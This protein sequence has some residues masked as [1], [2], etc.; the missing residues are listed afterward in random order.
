MGTLEETSIDEIKSQFE[1]N[2]F[3]AVRVT[4]AVIPMMKKAGRRYNSEYN[5]FGR[6]NIFSTKFSISCN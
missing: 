3:G 1:T 4:Q 6:K 2:F 5:V